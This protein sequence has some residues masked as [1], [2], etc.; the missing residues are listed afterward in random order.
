MAKTPLA[1][2][3]WYEDPA[4]EAEYTY[5]GRL[6]AVCSEAGTSFAL[7]CPSAGSVTLNLYEDGRTGDPVQWPMRNRGR[8]VWALE[9]KRN[10]DGFYYDYDVTIQGETVRTTDPYAKSCSANGTRDMVLDLRRTDPE[11]WEED[12]APKKGPETIIWEAHVKEFSWDKSGGFPERVRGKYTAFACPGTTV[13]GEGTFPT[14]TDYLKK[15]GITH[16]QLMPIYDFG[17]VDERAEDPDQEFNWGYDPVNYFIP[18][19]SYASDAEHGEVRVREVKEMVQAL[20]RAGLRV[21]MDV[22]FNHTYQLDTSLQRTVP[23]Y[24]YRLNPDGTLSNGSGCGNDIAAERP[25]ARKLIVDAVLYWAK[26]YHID[27]FRFDLMGLLPV[28]LMNEIQKRLDDTFGRGEKM[29][30][31]EPW[32]AGPTSLSTEEPLAVKENFGKLD[33]LIAMFSDDTRDA[34]KGSVFN[35]HEQG[36]INGMCASDEKMMRAI[37]AWRYSSGMPVKA[38][39]QIITYVSAHDN[40]TLWDKLAVTTQDEELRLRQNHMAAAVYMTC[41]GIPFLLS[42]EE[43]A[44]TKDGN[45]NSYNAPITLNRLDWN[46]AYAM[47]DLVRYYQG[48]IALRKKIPG[49]C[50][51]SEDAWRAIKTPWHED[52]IVGFFVSN[53][54]RYRSGACRWNRVYI[55][56]NSTNECSEVPLPAG[57]WRVLLDGEDSFLWENEESEILTGG[58]FHYVRIAP[59][60]VL[61]LGEVGTPQ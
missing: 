31:G 22:V 10:L 35:E 46:R 26:E 30:Y 19:G 1:W 9:T 4:F 36:F 27:G 23:W 21:N 41:Q 17:S 42:G 18:E 29:V 52:G 7:W 56:Y 47:R 51:K 58:E 34:I 5:R 45:S 38:P 60:S 8:G 32:A 28:S 16:V 50:D 25:M 61:I 20:H 59:V 24:F 49:L 54:A 6:G 48:L 2:K 33:V 55:L 53:A 3:E 11:G 40:Q 37:K 13:N 39:S 57:E 43:F 15:L 12:R 14:G 44:R